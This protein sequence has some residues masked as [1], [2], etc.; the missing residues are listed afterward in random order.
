MLCAPYANPELHC[1]MGYVDGAGAGGIDDDDAII[2][3]F[4]EINGN[5]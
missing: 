2:R 1:A 3:L 5:I 4:V